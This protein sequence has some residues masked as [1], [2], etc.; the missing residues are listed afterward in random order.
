MKNKK[1]WAK[2]QFERHLR[3]NKH[4][5][6]PGKHNFVVV[7]DNLKAT[8]N[9]GKIFRSCDAFGAREVH[10]IG[11]EY[12]STQPAKGAF[13]HVPAFF[14]DTFES[15]HK[16]LIGEGYS[17]FVL[18][19]EAERSLQESVLP[20]KSAFVFGHEEVGI[21]FD[22]QLYSGVSSLRIPQFGKVQSLNVS[23]AASVVVYEYLRQ[24]A[25]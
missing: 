6:E 4:F 22:S 1:D 14:H 20:L 24:H 9:I 18:D 15:C 2:R 10:L 25:L 13:K 3:H 7:L 19:P 16:K 12:F 21:S 5:A 8:F 11:T 17:F 23:V